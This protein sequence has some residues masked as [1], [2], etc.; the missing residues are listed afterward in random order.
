MNSIFISPSLNP[1]SLSTPD[2]GLLSFRLIDSS[3]IGTRIT[4]FSFSLIAHLYFVKIFN[5]GEMCRADC[6][7]ILLSNVSRAI[8]NPWEERYTI[9]C[10][11]PVSSTIEHSWEEKY[12][13]RCCFLVS[14]TIENPREEKETIQRWKNRLTFQRMGNFVNSVTRFNGC[15]FFLF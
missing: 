5:I 13:I 7:S 11:F 14:R 3:N 2:I 8:E 4:P 1:Y 9:R 10:C 6:S 15:F 12:T